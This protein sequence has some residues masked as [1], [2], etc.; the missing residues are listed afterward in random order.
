MSIPAGMLADPEELADQI[1]GVEP[2]DSRLLA[3]LRSA[4]RRFLGA[5]A[6]VSFTPI[7][8]QTTWLNGDG[9]DTLLL[10]H[11]PVTA[12]TVVELEGR[13][14]VQGDDYDWSQEGILQR[15]RGLW[16]GRLRAV[17][18]V[19]DHGYTEV[20]ED[21]QAA[22]IDQAEAGYNTRR[23][24]QSVSVDG[25]AVTYGAREAVGVT[26]TWSDTVARYQ[27]RGDR[28]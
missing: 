11:L 21:V 1:G 6:P 20:P 23:G 24:V 8:G 15:V 28:A 27:L 7:T 19:Y 10:P 3:E 2:D 18:V 12:V 5:V 14:L 22:V 25:Q 26:Q 4:S 16:P 13:T 17:R 9:S